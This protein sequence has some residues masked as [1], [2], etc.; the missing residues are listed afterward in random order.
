MKLLEVKRPRLEDRHENAIAFI[1]QDVEGVLAPHNDAVVVTVNIADYNVHRVFINNGSS[2]DIL[3]MLFGLKNAGATYQ[4]LVN[5]IFKDQLGRNMKAY[6]DDMLLKSRTTPDHI[7]D[8]QET[9]NTLHRFQ[10]KLN[11]AKCAFEVTTS[12]FFRFMISQRGIE[13]NPKK[14]KVILEMMPSRTIEE[15][16]HLTDFILECTIP[17]G[18]SSE[19]GEDPKGGESSKAGESSRNEEVDAKSDPKELWTLHVDGS[20]NASRV[21]VEL[22]FTSSEGDIVGYALRFDF[23]ATNNEVEYKDLI[24][25]LKVASEVGAQHL[26]IFSD[27]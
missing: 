20:S 3:M 27:S 16:Q 19:A 26:K 11:L 1:E 18:Q 21:G 15:V 5:K 2:I 9:F 10:M 14:I 8:L 7:A 22:S 4:Q 13:T 17:N 25:G 24:A 12:K 23:S 6:V